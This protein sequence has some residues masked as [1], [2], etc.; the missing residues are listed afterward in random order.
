VNFHL[1]CF[2]ISLCF[3]FFLSCNFFP[4]VLI[5]LGDPFT[6]YFVLIFV[7]LVLFHIQISARPALSK[8]LFWTGLKA[9]AWVMPLFTTDLVSNP[10]C[11]DQALALFKVDRARTFLVPLELKTHHSLI[12]YHFTSLWHYLFRFRFFVGEPTLL[13]LC[14]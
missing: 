6:G 9:S 5:S 12:G 8:G 11:A 14:L 10:S 7:V 13:L 3:L 1:R 4:W 2:V